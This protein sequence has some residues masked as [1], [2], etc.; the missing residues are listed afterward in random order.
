MKDLFFGDIH[1]SAQNPWHYAAGQ[2]FIEWFKETFKEPQQDSRLWFLGDL[3]DKDQNPGNVVDQLYR[4]ISFASQQFNKVFLL[5]GNHD[6][7]LYRGQLQHALKFLDNLPNVEVIEKEGQYQFEDRTVLALPHQRIEGKSIEAFYNI[8]DFSGY[9][10]SDIAIGHWG[11]KD[12]SVGY[13]ADGVDLNHIPADHVICGHVHNRPRPEYTGSIWPCTISE[14]TRIYPRVYKT[15]TDDKRLIETPLPKFLEYLTVTYPQKI[16]QKP[17]EDWIKVYTVENIGNL[18]EA[19]NYYAPDYVCG[20]VR[21]KKL[22][23][24]EVEKSEFVVFENNMQALD[25]MLK[26]TQV[27]VSRPAFGVLAKLLKE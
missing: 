14:T 23:T 22:K 5:M 9:T 6:L 3:S 15:F 8:Y 25:A 1:F 20:I 12:E 2:K 4:L 21:P 17:D 27:K 13:T 7:K 24:D 18:N 11:I 26:E 19:K 16:E 10:Q